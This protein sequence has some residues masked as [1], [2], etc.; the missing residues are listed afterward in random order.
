MEREQGRAGNSSGRNDSCPQVGYA[1][2]RRDLRKGTSRAGNDEGL[3][4]GCAIGN[5]EQGGRYERRSVEIADVRDGRS[6]GV[7]LLFPDGNKAK[8]CE[9]EGS[10]LVRW[11][12]EYADMRIWDGER[13]RE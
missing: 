13:E 3:C 12:R 2:G 7:P 9:N 10:W 5:C 8:E 11:I 4:H 6:I 1:E